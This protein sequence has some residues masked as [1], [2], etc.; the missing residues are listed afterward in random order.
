MAPNRGAGQGLKHGGRRYGP[1]W[2][3]DAQRPGWVGVETSSTRRRS[4]RMQS[5]ARLGD[6]AGVETSRALM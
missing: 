4:H 6:W 5:G 3:R 2:P 1:F